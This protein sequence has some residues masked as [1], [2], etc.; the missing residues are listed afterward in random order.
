MIVTTLT[1]IHLDINSSDIDKDQ[2]CD[3]YKQTLV[4]SFNDVF[5]QSSIKKNTVR[6]RKLSIH[7]KAELARKPVLEK[8]TKNKRNSTASECVEESLQRQNVSKNL[9]RKDQRKT[10]LVAMEMKIFEV[11]LWSMNILKNLKSKRLHPVFFKPNRLKYT[12]NRF[13]LS[14]HSS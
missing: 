13:L 12:I 8:A 10:Q 2:T 11:K 1:D 14:D 4:Y 5:Q 9:R 7:H 3:T 6:K